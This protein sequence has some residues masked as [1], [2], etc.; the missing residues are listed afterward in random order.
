M[1]KQLDFKFEQAKADFTT[2]LDTVIKKPKK[3][4]LEEDYYQVLHQS[5]E[6]SEIAFMIGDL[7]EAIAMARALRGDTERLINDLE[8]FL[9]ED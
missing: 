3:L 5:M 9:M 1:K 2:D 6:A 4:G 7:N 8:D